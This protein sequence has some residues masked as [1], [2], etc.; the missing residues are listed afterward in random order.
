M[1]EGVLL[2]TSKDPCAKTDKTLLRPLGFSDSQREEIMDIN[3]RE[4]SLRLCVCEESQFIFPWAKRASF[5]PTCEATGG[6]TP[7]L[8]H[9]GCSL[10]QHKKRP[11]ISFSPEHCTC[12]WKV[13]LTEACS[14]C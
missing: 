8:K 10:I 4:F 2:K 5:P 3:N 7:H 9:Q 11:L 13:S 14:N 6:G 12:W 1:D